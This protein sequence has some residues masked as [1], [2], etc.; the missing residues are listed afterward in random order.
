VGETEARRVLQVQLT[1]QTCTW[2]V[3]FVAVKTGD[4]SWL[5]NQVDLTQAGNPA[6]PCDESAKT[7]STNPK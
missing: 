7:D 1:R 4:G 5:V 2:N 6:R 3:P